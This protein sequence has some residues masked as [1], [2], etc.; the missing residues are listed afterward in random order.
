MLFMYYGF[1]LWSELKSVLQKSVGTVRAVKF[2]ALECLHP[3]HLLAY[4]AGEG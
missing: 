3:M 1:W 4:G 2:K